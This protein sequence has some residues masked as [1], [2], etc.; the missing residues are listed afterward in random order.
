VIV[1]LR[2][3]ITLVEQILAGDPEG[4]GERK[5]LD[6]IVQR[7]LRR[8]TRALFR[9]FVTNADR[10]LLKSSAAA[11]SPRCARNG[12]GLLRSISR[13]HVLLRI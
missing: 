2:S 1:M 7:W 11:T 6:D 3:G 10:A 12:K 8:W 9:K 5:T 13:C 4:V